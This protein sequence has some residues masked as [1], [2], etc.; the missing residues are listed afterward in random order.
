MNDTQRRL[1][2]LVSNALF[3]TKEEK[4]LD[5]DIIAEAKRQAVWGI[6]DRK[7]YMEYANNINIQYAHAS[8][9]K[10]LDGIPFTT[11]KGFSSAYYYPDPAIRALGDVDFLVDPAYYNTAEKKLLEGGFILDHKTSIHR[12][13][14]K[15]GIL[16]EMHF[17][18]NGVPKNKKEQE[19]RTLLS[20][21]IQTSRTILTRERKE[22][23]IPDDFH[24]GLICLLH[25]MSHMRESGIGLRHFCDWAC[26]VDRVPRFDSVFKERFEAIGLWKCAQLFSLAAVK[27]L[28]L[29]Y[30]EWMG[31]EKEYILDSLLDEI[32]MSGN[33]GKTREIQTVN[34]FTDKKYS[35]SKLYGIFSSLNQA[36]RS[37]WPLV[38]KVPLIYPFGWVFLTTR[39]LFR[40]CTGKRKPVQFR[41]AVNLADTKNKLIHEMRL[42]E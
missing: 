35:K 5:E 13:Y 30:K 11:I 23:V 32:M 29:P 6:I 12:C 37:N 1:L 28:G 40:I 36:V 20:D 9:S 4:T 41:Q 18:V 31:T 8:L 15:D 17:D 38:N 42:F 19:V 25:I 21:T 34:W 16:F 3:E 10:Y 39:Y 22:I 7:A 27:Y 14:W 24:N 33:L 2:S 26:L